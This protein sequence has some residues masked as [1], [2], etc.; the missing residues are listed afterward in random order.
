MLLTLQARKH[1]WKYERSPFTLSKI[2]DNNVMS[3]SHHVKVTHLSLMLPPPPHRTYQ[4]KNNPSQLRKGFTLAELLLS[5]SILAIIVTFNVQKI[6][7]I[8]QTKQRVAVQ[9][10][11]YMAF[12]AA[13]HEG[14]NNGEI[15]RL[16]VNAFLFQKLN[17]AKACPG[18]VYTDGCMPQAMKDYYDANLVGC[19]GGSHS[20]QPG[21]VLSNGALVWWR[22]GCCTGVGDNLVGKV[23][24]QID[25]NLDGGPNEMG[26][27]IVSYYANYSNDIKSDYWGTRPLRPGQVVPAHTGVYGGQI[28]SQ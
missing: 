7:G 2:I 18:G 11:A 28:F 13:I 3:D 9:K 4:G 21:L 1:R 14:T 17:A 12:A 5:M 26:E 8:N 24:M 10:E 22:D 6:I 25:T 19:C 16:G 23:W 27:D 20:G 15:Q